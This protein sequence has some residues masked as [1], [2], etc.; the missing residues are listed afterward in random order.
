MIEQLP[1]WVNVLFLLTLVATVVIFYYANGKR[2]KL[3]AGL[4]L[5]G[6]LQSILAITGFYQITD[7]LPPRF[8]LVLLPATIMIVVGLLPKYR[9]KLL[10]NRNLVLSTLLHTVRVPVEIVLFYL[11]M[12]GMIPELM[13]FEGRNFDIAAGLTAPIV[14]I[15][16][17]AKKVSNTMLIAWNALALC[18]VLFIL[19]NGI[20]SSELPFQQFGFEQPNRAI[21]YFPFILLPAVV[22]PIV[23]YTHLTDLI[24]LLSERTTVYN[25]AQVLKSATP[26]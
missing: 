24:A 4:I 2:K 5:W 20:L 1:H 12:Y 17:V 14:G 23:V 10:K 21:N 25:K 9:N 18:L 8:I 11:F 16:I 19:F 15:L 26:R 13:T 22:V 7:T 3:L 6:V